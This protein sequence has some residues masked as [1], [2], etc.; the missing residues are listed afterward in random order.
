MAAN[1][2]RPIALSRKNWLFANS[3]KGAVALC[4][5]YSII[6]TAK[7]NNLDPYKYLTYILTNI[8]IYKHE[9]KPLDDLLPWNVKLD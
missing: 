7:M 4:N 8:P 9:D 2:V 6:E 5:W 1:H 3:T